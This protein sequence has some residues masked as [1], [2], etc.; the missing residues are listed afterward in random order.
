MMWIL[1]PFFLFIFVAFPLFQG[2]QPIEWECLVCD[3][4][5]IIKSGS[6]S[7]LNET[8][9]LDSKKTVSRLFSL[10]RFISQ[11]KNPL[12]VLNIFPQGTS[13]FWRPPPI[14]Y[15]NHGYGALTHDEK[16]IS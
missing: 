11:V 12:S 10:I 4:S 1:F 13:P 8:L 6:D 16:G 2:D 5:F 9:G 15:S 3:N 7:P 14:E